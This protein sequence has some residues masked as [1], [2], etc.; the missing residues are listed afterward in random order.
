[1]II[2]LF[3]WMDWKRSAP[4]PNEN[5]LAAAVFWKDKL[6]NNFSDVIGHSPD[7]LKEKS[8]DAVA[9]TEECAEILDDVASQSNRATVTTVG[10]MTLGVL[11]AP[12]T[13][14]ASLAVAAGLVLVASAFIIKAL[15]DRG[16]TK[17]NTEEA[18]QATKNIMNLNK[19]LEEFLTICVY[20]FTQA[21]NHLETKEG[22][23][24]VAFLR[25]NMG[26]T[27]VVNPKKEGPMSSGHMTHYTLQITEYIVEGRFARADVHTALQDASRGVRI[28]DR[29]ISIS[30]S[31]S[32]KML[33]IDWDAHIGLL[34]GWLIL[35]GIV[36]KAS[37]RKTADDMK[38]LADQLNT[39]TNDLSFIY[40]SIR[41]YDN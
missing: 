2:F 39:T 36:K 11:A 41:G 9:M 20:A 30:R 31:S 24:F 6:E 22:K 15:H 3:Q 19:Q 32:G 33:S 5:P 18:Q 16:W 23:D 35:L 34:E 12:F 21:K 14:G 37:V 25:A 40:E 13:G 8:Y 27:G 29:Y 10:I 26:K 38:K 1:M 28:G 4:N 7:S 17:S